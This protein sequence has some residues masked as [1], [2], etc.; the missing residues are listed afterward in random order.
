MKQLKN[1]IKRN[2]AYYIELGLCVL[3]TMTIIVTVL[4]F[5]ILDL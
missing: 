2:P 5:S 1:E 3:F 4:T